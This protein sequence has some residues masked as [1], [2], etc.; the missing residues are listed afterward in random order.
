MF[1][2]ILI[3]NRGEIAIRIMRTCRE[4]GIATVAVFSEADRKSQHVRYADEAYCIGPA[5]AIESYLDGEAILEAGRRSGAHAI[6]P[7]YGFLSENSNFAGKCRQADLVFIGPSPEVIEQMGN[8]TVARKT[9]MESGVPVIPGATEALE[10]LEA[11]RRV[12]AEIGYP[13]MLKAAAGGGGK[14]MR[15]VTNENDL[16]DAFSA[17]RRESYASFA[18]SRILV[19][20]Y[21]PVARHIEVQ[22]LADG[23]GNV[24]HLF[25]RECSIQ[26]R[27][28]KVIEECPS[29]FV[30]DELRDKLTTAAVQA[31]T[32]V[33][34]TG[35]GT[36]EFLVDAAKNFYFLE[37]NTR[38]Q[39]EHP[40][41][42][43][44][45]GIDLVREQ[46]LAAAGERLSVAQSDVR[47]NGWAMEC[48]IY[49]EDPGNDYMPAPG[50]IRKVVF[51]EGPGVR[52]D[53][54]VYEG[55]EVSLHYDP[56]I[57]KI[58]VWARTREEAR[59]RMLRAL[60]ECI[61][62]GVKTN[63]DLQRAILTDETFISGKI[64]TRFLDRRLVPH[65]AP[66]ILADLA[67]IASVCSTLSSSPA[68][69]ERVATE[70]TGLWRMASKYQF[71]AT[72]F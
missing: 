23:H 3:A 71:W 13:V 41:T 45:T 21:F 14:G 28:Q 16:Q 72:R 56:M 4:M 70:E 8:K 26:R 33:G 46:L 68:R 67:I 18:D 60:D 9:M 51:P 12:C 37:M 10:D 64:D 40:V 59:C 50:Q 5:P 66:D 65:P 55:W 43:L 35:A 15:I 36:V 29:V 20:R 1:S 39:V 47:R 61:I 24:I 27:Y 69:E 62:Y 25:E 19:E 6:H 30:D 63:L 52:V 48:R 58:S 34:Y 7:G 2:K 11:V 38:I 57:A 32:V 44:V 49:A 31:A 22:I 17:V 54:G 42:E 53:S